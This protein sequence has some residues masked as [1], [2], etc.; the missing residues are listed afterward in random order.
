MEATDV[1][2]M[3]SQAMQ[4]QILIMSQLTSPPTSIWELQS[5][6][7]KKNYKTKIPPRKQENLW[8]GTLLLFRLRYFSFVMLCY[9][10]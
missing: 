5:L 8:L 2:V 7:R 3:L 10:G 9:A 1:L 4:T 6:N